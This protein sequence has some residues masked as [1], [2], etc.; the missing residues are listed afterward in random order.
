MIEP[1]VAFCD[2]NDNMDLAEDM[3]KYVI[4]YVLEHNAEDLAFLE[5]RLVQEEKSK[6]MAER[7]PMALLEKL[8]FCLENDFERVSYTDAIRILHATK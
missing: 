6:P 2:L 7:S 4:K 3:L 5:N 8:Q 1:E